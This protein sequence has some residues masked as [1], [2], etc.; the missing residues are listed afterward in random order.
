MMP[1][2]MNCAAGGVKEASIFC[3]PEEVW[4]KIAL[5]LSAEDFLSLLCVNRWFHIGLGQ[6]TNVWRMLSHRD[7]ASCYE[8]LKKTTQS[9]TLRESFDNNEEEKNDWRKE[10]YL[11]LFRCHKTNPSESGGGV[12]W[13]PVRPYGRFAGI[14][15]REGHISCVLSRHAISDPK[16][17]SRTQSIAGNMEHRLKVRERIVVVT[18]GFASDD[19][20]C[21]S[22]HTVTCFRLTSLVASDTFI[23]SILLYSQIS[24]MPE[25]ELQPKATLVFLGIDIIGAWSR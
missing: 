10:K 19:S 9:Q 3:L 7:G 18:G 2:S 20:I 22:R 12:H 5:N 13:Y 25:L 4:E 16:F 1:D 23:F 15:D 14:A 24:S 8:E 6:S 17:D 11:Y 21:E